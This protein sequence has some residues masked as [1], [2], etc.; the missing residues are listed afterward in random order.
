MEITGTVTAV[1]Q[2]ERGTTKT[3]S[4]WQ[5][6]GFVVETDGDYPDS[7]YL[8]LMGDKVSLCPAVG[9]R[10]TAHFDI[11]SR[12]WNGKWFVDLRCWKVSAEGIEAPAPEA[13][14]ATAYQPAPTPRQA[15]MTDIFGTPAAKPQQIPGAED[16]G[17][18][19]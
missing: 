16:D 12:E 9:N 3:G 8:T 11:S 6:C 2:I 13:F 18:P 15:T 5:K 10:V 17:L 19:F 7:A 4:T 1:T 14:T